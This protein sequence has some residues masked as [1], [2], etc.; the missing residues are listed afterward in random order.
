MKTYT[1]IKVAFLA[2]FAAGIASR[3]DG[4]IMLPSME[5]GCRASSESST[6]I[7]V[8]EKPNEN[9]KQPDELPPL[10][11]EV[12]LN[13]SYNHGCGN[14]PTGSHST[15]STVSGYAIPHC[16]IN[17][18]NLSNR[19]HPKSIRKICNPIPEPLLEPPR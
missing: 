15:V 7:P 19:L 11:Q 16:H 3:A 4:A 1:I 13:T 14:V 2:V 6:S 5:Y 12:I 17:I 9:Q 18:C 10:P 8:Q